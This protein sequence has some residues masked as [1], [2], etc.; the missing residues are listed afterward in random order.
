MTRWPTKSLTDAYWLQEGPRVRKWQ[1]HNSGIKLLNVA[2]ITK[3]GVLDLSKTDRH[4][5]EEEISKK[6][7]HFLVDAG[8]LVIASSGISFDEDGLLRTR[9]AFVEPRH[10]PLC[11]NTSTVR[12]K[13]KEGISTLAW[14]RYW[15]DSVEFRG[16]ITRLV[17]GSAQQNFGPSHLKATKITL[18]PLAEQERIVMLLDEADELR[19]LRAQADRRTTDLIPALF[20][21]MF[22]NAKHSWRSSA[23]GELVEDFRYG[24]SNKSTGEGK[25]ALRIPNVIQEAVN[26]DDLKFVPVSDS[27]FDRL[28]LKD[29]D[30][31]F[32][33]TN[34]NA[35]NVGRCA[36]FDARAI[37]AAGYNA[38][39]FIYASYLIR[40]RLQPE[41]VTPLFVQHFL[42]CPEGCRALRARSKTSAGQFNINT[43]GLCTIPI[44]VPP[45]PL[46]KEFAARVSEIRAMQAEQAASRRRLDDLFASLLHRAFNGQL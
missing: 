7:S 45:L 29:G 5:S 26:L 11:L 23:L 2:N 27:E 3:E 10:L 18:P 4:L 37:K 28:R 6:Y 46:Q 32:V 15:L 39:E 22:G 24:T 36:V 9:G 34:G 19:K 12:F 42:A 25:P 38:E 1:F 35:D 41:R 33:R 40:A 8:D 44:P 30:L 20:H 31:L 21:D 17:T 14:L 43:E 16:Q 13:S